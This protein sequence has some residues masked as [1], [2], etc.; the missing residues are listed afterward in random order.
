MTNPGTVNRFHRMLSASA[1]WLA[2]P[3]MT[4]ALFLVLYNNLNQGWS[5]LA[6]LLLL[7]VALVIV[8]RWQSL[9]GW[10]GSSVTAGSVCAIA[11]LATV[12]GV[13]VLFPVLLP[14]E[15]AQVRELAKGVKGGSERDLEW[16][17]VVFTNGE[18]SEVQP[19]V[20]GRGSEEAPI[21]WHRS[22]QVFQYHGY[23]PNEKFR[24]LNLVRWNQRGYF[25]K[26]YP[27]AKPAHVFRIV[28]I[29]DSFVEAVQVPLR[30]TFHKV[31]EDSLNRVSTSD[32]APIRGFDV[33]ALGSSGT[34]QENH[35]SVLRDEA[36]LYDPDI[37]VSTLCQNDFCDD[38][39]ALRK[40]RTLAMGDV[41]TEFRS[42]ARH[43]Y[44]AMGFAVRRFNEFQMNRIKISPELLQWSA[45]S[46]PRIEQA[47]H[48]TLE[49]IR[50]QSDFCRSRGIQFALVY[51]G[52]E[53]E[54]KHALDP[55]GTSA[56][57]RRMHRLDDTFGW[58][59]SRSLNR[60][61]SYCE[62]HGIPMISLP[63]P[64]AHAQKQTGKAVF[65]DHYSIFGH[66]IAAAALEAGLTPLIAK[67]LDRPGTS[68]QSQAR[69][70]R[71]EED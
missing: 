14:R 65:G 18:T 62:D 59:M 67:A 36:V 2:P 16:F 52:S 63:E 25:D 33:I 13:E 68:Q 5:I 53:L 35:L 11:A 8:I 6:L 41:T 37:V 31:L 57:L 23:E 4:I 56:A 27:Y 42:L 22:G 9:A 55:Q 17:T 10:A 19:A 21:A 70:A 7:N 47:W 49:T 28:F 54:V 20:A 45:A 44:W 1:A 32:Q 60:V 61:K 26:D 40:E 12:M 69:P 71:P 58:D 29:G 34:G 66:E 51:L 38:D 30:S 24:Y 43:G 39:P 64:L 50:A 46:V 15:Y 48:R 3:A